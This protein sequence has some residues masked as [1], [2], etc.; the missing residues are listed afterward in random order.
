MADVG[1]RLVTDQPGDVVLART[2]LWTYQLDTAA[3]VS[4]APLDDD[5]VEADLDPAAPCSV[6]S[7]AVLATVADDGD[8]AGLELLAV[9]STARRGRPSPAEPPW[10][11]WRR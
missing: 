7:G 11:P 1:V 3:E 2:L 9:H 8:L 4:R 5:V 10:G 6:A